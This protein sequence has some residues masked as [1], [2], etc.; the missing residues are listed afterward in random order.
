MKNVFGFGLAMLL[1]AGQSLLADT[2][3]SFFAAIGRPLVYAGFQTPSS[4]HAELSVL[5]RQRKVFANPKEDD[6]FWDADVWGIFLTSPTQVDHLPD[7]LQSA[8]EQVVRTEKA[9]PF[10]FAH[11]HLDTGEEKAIAFVFPDRD[12]PET[13]EAVCRAARSIYR[14]VLGELTSDTAKEDMRECSN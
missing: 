12:G 6:T 10:I 5:N 11:I 7:L 14:S 9:A 1:V 4:F 3:P 8:Y 2:R 13:D